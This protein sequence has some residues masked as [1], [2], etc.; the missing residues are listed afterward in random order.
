M[1]EAEGDLLGAINLY[2][3]AGLP[4]KAARLTMSHDE[5]ISSG[6]LVSRIASDLLK[7]EFFEQVSAAPGRQLAASV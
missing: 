5:L 2:L 6:E 7:G 1:K 4:A 3:R